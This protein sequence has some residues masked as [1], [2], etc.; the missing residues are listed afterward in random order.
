M[1]VLIQLA[2]SAESLHIGLTVNG[3]VPLRETR[4]LAGAI[5]LSVP[6]LVIGGLVTKGAIRV[7]LGILLMLWRVSESAMLR[8]NRPRTY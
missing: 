1:R 5:V 6:L 2:Q 7:S 3:W 8:S 4:I